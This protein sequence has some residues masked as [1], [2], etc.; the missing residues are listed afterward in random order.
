MIQDHESLVELSKDMIKL[1]EKHGLT[2]VTG[3]DKLLTLLLLI[4]Y[5]M[6][7]L[8][9]DEASS[10]QKESRA[11]Q[12]SSIGETFKNVILKL[13]YSRLSRTDQTALLEYLYRDVCQVTKPPGFK[14]NDDRNQRFEDLKA[15][16]MSC[17]L[18]FFDDIIKIPNFFACYVKPHLI[19]SNLQS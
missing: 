14:M 3:G 16:L 2:K 17:K 13:E 8:N 9:C 7:S 1:S 12:S 19:Q 4:Q 15:I 5:S 10:R 6:A 11:S 18:N